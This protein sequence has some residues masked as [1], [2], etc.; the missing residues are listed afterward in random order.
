MSIGGISRQPRAAKTSAVEDKFG[1]TV[2]RLLSSPPKK[3]GKKEGPRKGAVCLPEYEWV[4]GADGKARRVKPGIRLLAHG[5]PGRV[6]L[7]RG[8]GNAID[9][10]PAVAFIQAADEAMRME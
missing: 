5:I 10:R 4:I 7:L 3:A 9:P 1:R 2:R 6:G 8:F